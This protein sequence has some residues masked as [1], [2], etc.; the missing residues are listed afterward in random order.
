MALPNPTTIHLSSCLKAS[1]IGIPNLLNQQLCDGLPPPFQILWVTIRYPARDGVAQLGT[2]H[3]CGHRIPYSVIQRQLDVEQQTQLELPSVRHKKPEDQGGSTARQGFSYQDDVAVGFVLDMIENHSLSDVRC[4]TQDDIVL[5]WSF[6]D[7]EIAEYVQVKSGNTDKLWS[8]AD[9]CARKHKDAVGTSLYERSL[10]RD[11]HKEESRFR[12]VTRIP[13]VPEMQVLTYPLGSNGRVGNQQQVKTVVDE[14]SKRLPAVA[15]AKGH[16]AQFWVDRCLWCVAHDATAVENANLIRITQIAACS[17]VTLFPEQAKALLVELRG[18]VKDASEAPWDP[19]PELKTLSRVAIAKW[20]QARLASL[21]PTTSAGQKLNA[22]LNDAKLPAEQ[23]LL[24]SEL[25]RDY[26]MEV[27]AQQYM[28]RDE[29]DELQKSVRAELMVLG[30]KYVAG[31]LQLS[32]SQF[33]AKCIDA[34][35]QIAMSSGGG[36]STKAFLMGCMYDIVDR[37]LHRFNKQRAK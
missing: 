27:R 13:A 31:D 2:P 23:I 24:A 17:G 28:S 21:E 34:V 5:L 37:C 19:D 1:S 26:A 9:V 35:T 30:S 25:R 15:S 20:W 3:R 7:G 32:P 18:K 10:S 14:L 36:S 16:G 8:I 4:E 12:I 29:V 22:K 6:P 11:C 33:H